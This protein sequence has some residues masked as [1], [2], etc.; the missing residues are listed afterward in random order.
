[1]TP[2]LAFSALAA[3]LATAT[4]AQEN[5]LTNPGFESGKT[6]WTLYVNSSA[7]TE[8]G[9]PEAVSSAVAGAARTGTRGLQV[10]VSGVNGNNWDVQVQP[11]QTWTAE[12]GRVYHMT[13]WG[14]S[15][16]SKPMTV[17]ASLG[18]AAG[19]AY[20]DGWGMSLSS[21]WKQYEV[22][23]KSP[24][25]GVDSLRLN[26]YL[27]GD[28]G[29]YHLDDF[30]LD[31]VPSALP[32]TM[33]QPARGAWYTGVYRNLF[34]ELG[35][36]QANVDAKIQ[37][38]FAQLFLTGDSAQER[39]LFK[40]PADTTMAYIDNVEGYVLTEG[41]SY[42]MMI[43]LQMDRKDLFDKLWKFAKLHMQQHSGDRTGYFA[44]KVSTTPPYTPDDYNPAPDGEEYFATSLF[45]AAKRWGNGTG[46]FDYQ[47]QADS[48]LTYFTKAKTATMLPL[49]VPDRKQ[50]VFS[51]AQLD[52]PYTDPSYH[53]PAFSRVWDAF[54]T[55]RKAGFFAAMADTS[56]ALLKRAQHPVTGLYPEYSTFDGAPKTTGLN[57]KSHT[58]A[59]DAHRV[60][61]NIGFSWAWFMDD[62]GAVR[63]TKKQLG[64]FAA[65][66]GGYKAEYT[67][68]GVAQVEYVS[69]SIQAANAAAVLAS[70]RAADWS[71]VDALWKLPVASGQYRYYNG[72][73]QMLN[74]LHVSGKFKAWGSPGLASTGISPRAAAIAGFRAST[75][76]RI[77]SVEGL[78]SEVR[79][80]DLQGRELARLTPVGGA[81]RLALPRSGS[82]IVD[83]G[84]QGRRLVAAP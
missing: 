20:L 32:T 1:M 15:I 74:L 42:A 6:G 34:N 83:G 65:Q 58:F 66:T 64:F 4:Q 26:V 27:G 13:F 72:L 77:L 9:T 14:R 51:P 56:W 59:S 30:V 54:A 73:V 12:K 53:L 36:S 52:D 60:A 29:T 48:L 61:S 81:A 17:S 18:P 25:T 39:L 37:T 47:T 28:T 49:I 19:Y 41:Q 62:T 43:A 45:F 50:I 44:W 75:S 78:T 40:A 55:D 57:A 11:P 2:R 16:G 31:T 5:L 46:I 24:A 84:A 10:V 82:W 38:A 8:T 68:D 70:D 3:L 69:Q 22:F 80:L 71:F 7:T 21:S 79:V 76:G 67:L 33:V 63:M 35:Y 23:Y